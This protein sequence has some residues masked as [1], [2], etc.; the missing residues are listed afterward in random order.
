MNKLENLKKKILYRSAYRG[1]K[2]LDLLL[3]S[4]VKKYLNKL[5]NDELIELERFLDLEDEKI[6]NFYQ[7]DKKDNEIKNN[8]ITKLFKEFKL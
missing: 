6:M 8:Y 7:F 3:S 2:E 4:F 1:T 5:G